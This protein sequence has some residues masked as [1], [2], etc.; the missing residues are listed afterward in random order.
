[1]CSSL[2]RVMEKLE[3][4]QAHGWDYGTTVAMVTRTKRVLDSKLKFFLN[5][6]KLLSLHCFLIGTIMLIPE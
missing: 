3:K 4:G 2:I 6:H 5:G 1:M